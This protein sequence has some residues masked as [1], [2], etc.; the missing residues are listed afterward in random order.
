MTQREVVL[1]GG[2]PWGFRMHGGVDA[3]TPLKVSRVNPGSKAA[4]RGIR[5]GDLITTINSRSTK[6]LTNS[7]A[8]NLL[9]NS[10]NTLK[11]G[12]N[13]DLDGS[14]KR[15]NYKT[16]RQETHQET[17]KRS[18]ITYS[19]NE[20]IETVNKKFSSNEIGAFNNQSAG[21]LN[22]KGKNN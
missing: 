11:L 1:E 17:I 9:K 2:L 6:N 18:S 12:L 8:H 21:F 5:E 3:K 22:G 20:T 14:P 15:R 19:L 16:I 13:E 4:Q 10:G 7:E